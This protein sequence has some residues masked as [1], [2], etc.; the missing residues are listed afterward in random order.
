MR[1]KTKKIKQQK[2]L[3]VLFRVAF[4]QILLSWPYAA[5]LVAGEMA[6]FKSQDWNFVWT[7]QRSDK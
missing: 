2:R 1:T 7:V 4:P 6:G 5:G 3:F